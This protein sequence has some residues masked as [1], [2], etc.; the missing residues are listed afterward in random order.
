M[1]RGDSALPTWSGGP[2]AAEQVHTD[3]SVTIRCNPFDQPKE[4]GTCVT[5]EKPD[6]RRVVFA[7]AYRFPSRYV[8]E[9]SEFLDTSSESM[10]R[11]HCCR[12]IPC[13]HVFCVRLGFPF[14]EGGRK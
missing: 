11:K 6:R 9:Q 14:A 8:Q 3:L 13:W 7:K 12:G 10:P 2:E 1:I 5:V 4:K